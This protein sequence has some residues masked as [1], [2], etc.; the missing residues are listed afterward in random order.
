M[1]KNEAFSRVV[2]DAQL[3][4]QCWN[5]QGPNDVRYEAV[6]GDAAKAQAS[7]GAPVGAGLFAPVLIGH[8]TG[9]T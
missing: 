2:I 8:L 9:N 7:F 3:A 6:L 5:A 1:N 4:D